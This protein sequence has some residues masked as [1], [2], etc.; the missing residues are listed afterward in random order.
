MV[1]RVMRELGRRLKKLAYNWSDHGAVKIAR[2][3]LKKFTDIKGWDD[4]WKKRMK[5]DGNVI[6]SIANFRVIS[7]NLEH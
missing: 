1:E 2:I 6:L 5:L 3:V 4:Y 7:Q